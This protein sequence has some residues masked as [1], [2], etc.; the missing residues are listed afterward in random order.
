MP[1]QIDEIG[2]GSHASNGR[3][4]AAM[5]FSLDNDFGVDNVDRTTT[6]NN[7]SNS[8]NNRERGG[9]KKLKARSSDLD[10]QALEI[11]HST[12]GNAAIEST[13]FFS[14]QGW[15]LSLLFFSAMMYSVMGCFVKLALETTQQNLSSTEIVWFRALFQFSIVLAA[16]CFLTPNDGES[17]SNNDG[18]AGGACVKTDYNPVPIVEKQTEEDIEDSDDGS[19]TET[20]KSHRK[21]S[22]SRLQQRR[23][24]ICHNPFGPPNLYKIV[25]VRG[26]VGGFG[27]CLYYFTISALPLGD[28]VTILS[29]NPV[30]TVVLASIF[31]E[32]DA[33]V[34]KIVAA[35]CSVIGALLMARPSFL[36]GSTEEEKLEEV[37]NI[38]YIT[39]LLGACCG[40]TV[41][42][43]I[44]KAGKKGVHT[45]NMLFSWC[46]FG[47]T[48]STTILLFS[49]ATFVVPSST[50]VR[51]YI[52][53][54][55]CSGTTAH[56][57]LNYAAR[58]TPAGIASI[59]RS[60]GI[61]WSYILEVI[62][63]NQVPSALTVTGVVLIATSLAV[64]AM[65][66]NRSNA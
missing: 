59:V 40:A 47:L 42:I 17:D 45:L 51:L 2:L 36:F 7:N 4:S 30:V 8:E 6:N 10:F 27:F 26:F 25:I 35:T 31:L 1:P 56:F 58:K 49:S 50:T 32:E 46:V 11:E 63:F 38:G 22:Q 33:T 18:N 62:V 43:L 16:M 61:L 55:C 34:S 12:L 14:S 3:T 20:P 37:N 21:L 57:L 64:V 53:L 28:A 48:I 52:L 13:D 44:R 5:H 23:P 9:K 29:L 66:K 15:Y 54:A 19:D 60:S 39:G 65:D 41:Y 24:L